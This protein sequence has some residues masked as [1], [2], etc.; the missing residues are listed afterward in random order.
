MAGV[1]D[2][3]KEYI[4][5]IKEEVSDPN[6]TRK[7]QNKEWVYDDIPLAQLGN[8]AYPR[9]SV[10]CFG[11]PSRPHELNSNKQ[12][13][14]ARIEVQI[15]VRRTK[16]DNKSPQEFLDDLTMQ[17]IDAL[18]K[19]DS[20]LQLLSEVGTFHQTLE[21]ENTTYGDDVLVKQLIYKNITRR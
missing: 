10:V 13:I 5:I 3:I 17:V 18:R 2:I 19:N 1:H 20:R 7:T 12:R 8:T 14:N 11:A 9:I 6:T 16:W 4:S 21:A 15:R